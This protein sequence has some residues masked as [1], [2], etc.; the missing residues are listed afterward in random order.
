VSKGFPKEEVFGLT[1]QLSRAGVS[2]PSNIAEGQ[3]RKSKREFLHHLSIAHGSL[4]EVEARLLIA[5]R[6]LFPGN[7][8]QN[9]LMALTAEVGRLNNGLANALRKSQDA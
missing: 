1:S 7:V 9:E 4:G 8:R 3:G 2:I 5:S 6:L